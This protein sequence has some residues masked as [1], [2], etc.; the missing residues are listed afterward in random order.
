[1]RL[2]TCSEV[3]SFARQLESDSA[4]FYE[5]IASKN[6][7][8]GVIFQS[9]AKE[10]KK[11]TTQVERAY[12]SVISD[13][14]EGCFAFD[15]EQDDYTIDT[16]LPEGASYSNVLNKAMEIEQKIESFYLF[17]AE[18]SDKLMAD[19]PRAMKLVAKKRSERKPILES[20]LD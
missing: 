9:F 16:L 18:Q 6:E 11:Y 19:V 15:L 8:D 4:K 17:A 3:I 10:N 5:N 14:I 7:K 12:Y 2:H 1:V 20:L 13:A